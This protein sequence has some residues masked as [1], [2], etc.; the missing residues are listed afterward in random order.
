VKDELTGAPPFDQAVVGAKEKGAYYTPD[1]VV[2]SLLRWAV[3]SAGDRLL[4]PSCG[5]GRFIA[6]HAHSVGIEQDPAA[7]AIAMRRAPGALVHDGD[8]FAWA[9]STDERFDCAAGNPPFIRYQRFTGSVRERAIELC[10]AIG[11]T[12]SALSS[13]WPLFLVATAHL[14]R[15]GGRMAFVVPAEIGHAPYSAPLIEYL[16]ANFAHLQIIAVRRKLFPSLSQDCWLLFAD[17][18]GG[19]TASIAFSALDTFTYSE[20]PPV[21]HIHV[22]LSPWRGF[23]SKRLRAFLLPQAVRDLYERLG[24]QE[25]AARF[26]DFAH[27]NIGYVSGANDFFHLRP[28]EADRWRIPKAFLQDSVRRSRDLPPA[29]LTASDLRRWRREDRPSLL[30][31]LNKDDELP[32]DL[33]KLLSSARAKEAASA[34]KCRVRDPWYVVPDVKIPD[35]F[36]S[37]MSGRKVA[38]VRN[39]ARCACTNS[40]HTVRLKDKNLLPRFLAAQGSPLFQLSCEIE[41][42]PLGGGM[43]KLEPREAG[44]VLFPSIE[45]SF[46]HDLVREGTA[47]LQSW[48]HYEAA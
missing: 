26:A 4:D 33:K 13:S 32:S 10:S 41:G 36:L 31:R 1:P 25:G 37:Y 23:W 9:G 28:S 35:F 2:R 38:F 11:A 15:P 39:A 47:L 40:L 22:D 30:L 24:T 46:D 34:Y 17:G 3:R 18:K 27:I 20:T 5:D 44:R 42:H 21:P 45:T 29:E 12:F 43:L 19:S 14:L 6:G 7:S 8:F 48:R 16:A